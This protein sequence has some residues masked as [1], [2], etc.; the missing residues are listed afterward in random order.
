MIIIKLLGL[1]IMAYFVMNAPAIFRVVRALY[2]GVNE[3]K[4]QKRQYE[5][6]TQYESQGNVRYKRDQ[7]GRKKV[8]P[9]DEG[10]YVDYEEVKE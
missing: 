8:I 5:E 7:M 6:R 4:E 3:V 1:L 9:E 2:K 10:E